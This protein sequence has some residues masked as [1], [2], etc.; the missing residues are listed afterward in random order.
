QIVLT[1]IPADYLTVRSTL[2]NAEPKNIVIQ[3]LV[4]ED[5]VLGV[6]EVGFLR[7][8]DQET[9]LFLQRAGVSLAVAT[10]VAQAHAELTQLYEETQ[11]QAE[12]LE[13]QQEELRVQQEDRKSV[14]KGRRVEL[15][16]R[17]NM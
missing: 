13:A 17:G 15:G 6:M 5:E 3:P 9:L 2:G 11:Q 12:E 7:E 1:D 16:R 14:V 4:Y 8:I 10:K